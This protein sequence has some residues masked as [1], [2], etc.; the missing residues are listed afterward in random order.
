MKTLTNRFERVKYIAVKNSI[1]LILGVIFIISSLLNEN[2]LTV[3]NLRNV[4]RQISVI[5]ILAFGETLLIIAGMIDLSVGAVFAVAGILSITVFKITGSLLLAL[6]VGILSGVVLNIISGMLVSYFKTP[7]FIA[8]LALMTIAR[9]FV[10]LI[11][12]GQNIY[13]IGR[14][15]EFGQGSIGFIPTPVV[16]MFLMLIV[17]WYILNHTR[18]GRAIYAIGG[19]EEAAM[20]SGIQVAKTKFIVY[21]INGAFVGLAG[22]LF[23]SRVNAGL[24]NAGIGFELEALT[25]AI[26]GGTSF[27][28]GIGTAAGTLAGGFIVGLLNNI[29]NLVGVNSYVQQI[30]KG[31]IIALAVIFDMAAKNRRA[32]PEE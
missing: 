26:I 5:T 9:G 10:L 17:T 7:P 21:V 16:F 3:L 27:S 30:I 19:N 2:F 12:K 1:Y 8:T 28:G 13:Q 32:R 24:P 25:V 4:L 29:M 31:V 23:M 11:T 6:I 18:L 22:V 15:V 14:F 20:A